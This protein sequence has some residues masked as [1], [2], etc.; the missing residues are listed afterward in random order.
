[1]EEALLLDSEEDLGELSLADLAAVSDF[2]SE[3]DVES[4]EELVSEDLVSDE[5]EP[6]LPE[7]FLF[8]DGGLGRP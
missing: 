4:L 6:S 7:P 8:S 5:D 2:E 3:D 1:V